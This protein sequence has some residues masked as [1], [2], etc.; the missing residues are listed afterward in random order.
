MLTDRLIRKS[1]ILAFEI[2]V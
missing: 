2:R 1:L